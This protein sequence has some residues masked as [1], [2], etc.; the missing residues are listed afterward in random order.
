MRVAKP[1]RARRAA[2]LTALVLLA[3][4]PALAA[5]EPARGFSSLTE[6]QVAAIAFDVLILRPMGFLQTMIGGAIL[7][8]ACLIELPAWALDFEGALE[9]QAI[10]DYLVKAPAE[11]LFNRPLGE[12][13]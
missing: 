6:E 2:F 1:R 7:P 12:L 5:D 9:P 13:S 3:A 11:H 10:V 8:I 4:A